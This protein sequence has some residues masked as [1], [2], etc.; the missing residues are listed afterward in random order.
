MKEKGKTLTERPQRVP[1]TLGQNSTNLNLSSPQLVPPQIL[2]PS[3]TL[4]YL[5][6]FSFLIRH[7]A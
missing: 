1:E 7:E 2:V 4:R 3:L 6:Y 5:S